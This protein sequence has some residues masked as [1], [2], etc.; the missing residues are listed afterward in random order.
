MGPY[1]ML[2]KVFLKPEFSGLP[3][4]TGQRAA[5]TA[6]SRD[7]SF[8]E[9]VDALLEAVAHQKGVGAGGSF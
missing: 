3:H 4:S 6:L 9:A 1:C 2:Q 7:M 8:Y 5:D